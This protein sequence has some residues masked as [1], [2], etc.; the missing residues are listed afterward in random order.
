MWIPQM[1]LGD[2]E[3]NTLMGECWIVLYFLLTADSDGRQHFTECDGMLAVRVLYLGLMYWWNTRSSRSERQPTVCTRYVAR[4]CTPYVKKQQLYP[5]HIKSG[6]DT[7]PHNAPTITAFCQWTLQ[8]SAKDPMFAAKVYSQ[9]NRGFTR[10]GFTNIH[11]EYVWS[12]EYPYAI[13]S[14]HQQRQSSIN[15]WAGMLRDCLRG[16]HILSARVSGCDYLY[17]LRT[18]LSGLS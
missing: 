15:L 13:R 2:T 4:F 16:P 5:C 11:N 7:V 17:F 1:L 10:N 18:R 6:Q 8:Q 3:K 9:T 12:D 14:H